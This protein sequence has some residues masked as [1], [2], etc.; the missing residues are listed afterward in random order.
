MATLANGGTAEYKKQ[1][2]TYIVK[3]DE[4]K[5]SKQQEYANEYGVKAYNQGFYKF[6]PMEQ[7]ATGEWVKWEDVEPFLRAAELRVQTAMETEEELRSAIRTAQRIVDDWRELYF[8]SKGT[9]DEVYGYNRL[10]RGFAVALSIILF[11]V[12]YYFVRIGA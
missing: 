10:W 11:G 8:T 2:W 6:G 1:P 7:C 5:M 4:V 12:V 3:L 9:I